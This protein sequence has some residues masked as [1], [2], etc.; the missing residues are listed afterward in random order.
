M[1]AST[2]DGT[3]RVGL[4][5]PTEP[6]VYRAVST[7]P[8]AATTRRVSDVFDAVFIIIALVSVL[9]FRILKED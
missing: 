9:Q 6:P 1:G 3:P 5:V 2:Q 4:P 8:V 7:K